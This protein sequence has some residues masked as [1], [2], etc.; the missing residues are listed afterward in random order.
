MKWNEGLNDELM[1]EKTTTIK[2]KNP[3]FFKWQKW[4]IYLLGGSLGVTAR[5]VS[6]QI[7][8]YNLYGF[9]GFILDLIITVSFSIFII[10]IPMVIGQG[11]YKAIKK[12]KQR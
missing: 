1:N 12:R 8:F 3:F 2:N 10:F 6:P 9:S 5:I 11:I 4:I 7:G